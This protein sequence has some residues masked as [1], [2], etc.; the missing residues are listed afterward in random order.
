M[1]TLAKRLPMR[2][3]ASEENK[4]APSSHIWGPKATSFIEPA[5]ELCNPTTVDHQ[6]NL[7]R[8]NPK[9]PSPAI[10]AIF[11]GADNLPAFDESLEMPPHHERN[12]EQNQAA[13]IV[14]SGRS[15]R[16]TNN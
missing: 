7:S 4:R 1:D 2:T 5:Y 11:P 14:G 6:D 12:P 10:V 3:K 9:P 8:I 13:C 15:R 16:R